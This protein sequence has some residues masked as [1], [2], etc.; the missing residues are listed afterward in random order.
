M[1]KHKT[2]ETPGTPDPIATDYE[3]GT[4]TAPEPPAD[5]RADLA[6]VVP[7]KWDSAMEDPEHPLHHHCKKDS[8]ESPSAEE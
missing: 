6:P 2:A 7:P 4:P 3:D 1:P 8:L 5:F